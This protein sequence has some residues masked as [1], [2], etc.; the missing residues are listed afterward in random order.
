MRNAHDASG[1]CRIGNP[2]QILIDHAELLPAVH[3][4]DIFC[5]HIFQKIIKALELML[6]QSRIKHDKCCV[7]IR[8]CHQTD[9]VLIDTLN[10]TIDQIT[11]AFPFPVIQIARMVDVPS[12]C[13]DRKCYT[14]IRGQIRVHLDIINQIV[15]AMCDVGD[16]LT[17]GR[18]DSMLLQKIRTEL[19]IF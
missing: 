8:V 18:I 5:R 14:G 6:R 4:K 7:K 11:R 9:L 12:I 19:R 15:L 2:A 13:L 16:L 17:D 10:L 3:R 1:K